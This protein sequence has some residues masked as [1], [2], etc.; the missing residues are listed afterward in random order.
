MSGTPHKGDEVTDTRLEAAT[1]PVL[2]AISNKDLIDRGLS[3]RP[4]IHRYQYDDPQMEGLPY[5][6]AFDVG[7]SNSARYNSCICAIIKRYTD[8]GLR[9]LALT[10][11]ISHA[12]MIAFIAN[13][14][15]ISASFTHGD[16]PKQRQ[17]FDDFVAGDIAVLAATPLFDEDIDIDV[18]DVVVL[19]GQGKSQQRLLQRIGRGL[20]RKSGTKAQQLVV[21]DV[22]IVSND[23]FVKHA[24]LRV[25]TYIKE[26]FEVELKC[27]DVH[28]PHRISLEDAPDIPH[29]DDLF[30]AMF[31]LSAAEASVMRLSMLY[32]SIASDALGHS[33]RCVQWDDPKRSPIWQ[34]LVRLDTFLK[35]NGFDPVCFL[36]A[37]FDDLSWFRAGE[38]QP[39]YDVASGIPK[40]RGKMSY[41]PPNMMASASGVRRYYTR[42]MTYKNRDDLKAT[43]SQGIIRSIA[44]SWYS[45]ERMVKARKEMSLAEIVDMMA[46]SSLSVYWLACYIDHDPSA[47]T[48]RDRMH[49]DRFARIKAVGEEMRR[50]QDLAT[51]MRQAFVE[52]MRDVMGRG[53]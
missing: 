15:G 14:M 46:A 4:I 12:E 20:R 37:Q 27:I 31:D 18:I 25:K 3:A 32:E 7:V 16:D 52:G 17:T 22:E 53:V 40:S 13:G 47:Y 9:V 5:R 38:E 1:G 29:E 51:A 8:A 10:E 36:L 6:I 45:I 24:A 33:V 21:V 50:R 35:I 2:V 43:R 49:S 19:A 42:M 41:P 11:H 26:K 44:A 34:Q 39:M 28:L 48:L 23:Y 30:A